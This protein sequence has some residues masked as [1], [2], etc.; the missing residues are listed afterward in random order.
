MNSANRPN[1]PTSFFIYGI[2][3]GNG[4]GKRLCL[5]AS[6]TSRVGLPSVSLFY[7]L[8]NGDFAGRKYRRSG[9]MMKEKSPGT[10]ARA[11]VKSSSSV[12]ARQNKNGAADGPALVVHRI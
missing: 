8:A 9:A 2:L 5:E 1:S 7:R 4:Y 11:L 12:I 10:R 6:Y 3:L